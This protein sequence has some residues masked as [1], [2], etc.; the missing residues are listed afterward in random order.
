MMEAKGTKRKN[1]EKEKSDGKEEGV[2][3]KKP[4]R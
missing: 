1:E 2:K 3:K 4:N